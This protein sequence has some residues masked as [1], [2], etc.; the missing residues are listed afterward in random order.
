MQKSDG[1]SEGE[2]QSMPRSNLTAVSKPLAIPNRAQTS[3]GATANGKGVVSGFE[4][5]KVSSQ[6]IAKSQGRAHEASLPQ[7]QLQQAMTKSS[8]GYSVGTKNLTFKG[9][10]VGKATVVGAKNR[11]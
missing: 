3:Y 10:P 2:Q 1:D 8:G 9:K 7:K 4:Q 6:S 5:R 11:P